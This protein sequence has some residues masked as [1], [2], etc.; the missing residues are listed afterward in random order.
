MFGLSGDPRPGLR[1]T[2]A[3]PGGAASASVNAPGLEGNDTVKTKIRLLF[4]V[5]IAAAIAS[6]A[7]A[8]TKS[9]RKAAEEVLETLGVQAQVD[10]SIDQ[11][12]EAQAKAEPAMVPFKD[13]VKKFMTK[14]MSYASLKEDFITAYVDAF[15]EEELKEIAAFYKT[16]IGKKMAGKMPEVSYKLS[17]LGSKRLQENQ[18]ELMKMIQAE[19]GKPK[20]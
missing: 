6:T 17:Q 20:P 15:T 11:S 4:A 1:R 19:A 13:V 14:H 8:D 7:F 9:H 2:A 18:E 12:L 3:S 5:A 10:K 16:P